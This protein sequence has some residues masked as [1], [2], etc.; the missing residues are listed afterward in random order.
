MAR[1]GPEIRNIKLRD[2]TSITVG[3]GDSGQ[4]FG[5][6]EATREAAEIKARIDGLALR[7]RSVV[8]LAAPTGLRQSEAFGLKPGEIEF[9]RGTMSVIRSIAYGVVGPGKTESSQ[10][11]E[12]MHPTLADAPMQWREHRT[13]IRTEHG[14]REVLAAPQPP[15][16][17]ASVERLIASIRMLGSRHRSE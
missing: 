14:V 1:R 4:F 8:L 16:Q 11:P 2:Y 6:R 9:E 12:P 7:E 13:Y 5:N 3:P 17:H 15:R 10:K